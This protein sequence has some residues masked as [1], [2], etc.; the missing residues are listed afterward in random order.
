MRF[1]ACL[2][3]VI[4]KLWDQAWLESMSHEGLEIGLYVRYVDDSRN[5]LRPLSPG[6]RW[7]KGIGFV[8]NEQWADED[9]KSNINLQSRTRIELTEAMN[10][11]V[12][13]LRFTGEDGTM[14]ADNM[15]PTL[16][17]AMWISNENQVKF[18]F[19]EKPTVPNRVLQRDTALPE[20][21]I[22]ASLTQEVVRRLANCS[23]DTPG[24]VIRGILSN[25]AQ[26]MLNSGH[27]KW[28]TKIVLVHGV[29]KFRYR[30]KCSKLDTKD[31][32][33]KPLHLSKD[34]READ[35]QIDKCLAK[36]NW[37]KKRTD[38]QSN[39]A[40]AWR[41]EL[42]GVWR[43]S[44]QLQ[45]PVR[46]IPVTTVLQIP[47]TVGSVL[48]REIARVEPRLARATGYSTKLIKKGGIQL[49][50]LFDRKME[51][52]DCNRSDC[53]PCLT[54][55]KKSKCKKGNIVYRATCTQCFDSGS[56]APGKY[57]GETSRTLYERTNEHTSLLRNL[58]PK[59]FAVKHWAKDHPQSKNPPY[60][61]LSLSN[62]IG[63]PYRDSYMKP[64]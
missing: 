1:T 11:L 32:R 50:R 25:L 36:S 53:Q 27:S 10:E 19:Y 23:L 64:C 22:K 47:N 56:K 58:D 41:N 24:D 17:T 4:M 21:T 44:R 7:S 52:M 40:Q 48:M 49:G 3:A 43:G 42:R 57:I 15:L 20:S 63:T 38:G 51:K 35:R 59:S 14:F 31:S 9:K 39:N 54:T 60:S 12:W 26:K 61:N 16:D 29:T 6:W 5:M 55:D 30:V 62:S 13:F 8:Y 45:R 18:I 34:Y 33:F 37:H 2:A 28:Y 46:G